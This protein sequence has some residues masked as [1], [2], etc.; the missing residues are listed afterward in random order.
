MVGVVWLT[1]HFPGSVCFAQDSAEPDSGAAPGRAA[2]GVA[3]GVGTFI[4]DGDYSEGAQPRIASIGVFRYIMSPRFRAQISPGH[5]WTAYTQNTAA[6][7]RDPNFPA[8][9][10]KDEYLTQLVPVTL[11]LQ[12][13]FPRGRWI[14]HV[15]AGPG[16]YRVWVQ[17]RRKVLKDPVSKV[18]HRGLYLGATGQIG[19][20][21]FLASLPS[22]SVEFTATGHWVF[23]E[24]DEGFLSGFNSFLANVDL[25]VGVNYYFTLPK[26]RPNSTLPP[27]PGGP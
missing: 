12:V 3:A 19:A 24:D 15:G 16:L 17:N 27:T 25:K 11:Q 5:T 13:M 22:T 9:S 23:A 6:P 1:L 14:Y 20:E 10:L 7:F 8:D 2:V 4:A 21:R 26:G 18:L